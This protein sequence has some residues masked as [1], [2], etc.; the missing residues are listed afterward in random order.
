MS[1][2]SVTRRS[3][4][5]RRT[6]LTWWTVGIALYTAMIM[7]VWPVIEGNEEF[8][9]LF[10]SYPDAIKALMGGPDAFDAFTTPTGFLDT[11]LYSMILP[12][13]F[14]GLAVAIGAALLGG[15]EEEGLLE[16]VLSYPVS[17]TSAVLQKGLAMGAAA[18]GL[19]LVV[20]VLIF[21]MGALVDL[22][23]GLGG[24]AAATL[25]TVLFAL[26]HGQLAMLTGAFTGR[27]GPSLGVGW[28]VALGGYLLSV[29]AGIDQSLSWLNWLSPLHYA[30]NDSP[31]SDG[32]TVWFLVLL[33]ALVLALGA[34]VVAFR[35]HDLR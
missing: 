2:L 21:G 33:A 18:V 16:L 31:I 32:P 34:T 11:Y 5:D 9:E 13:I 1:A 14:V 19:G 8:S 24:L 12:F 15:D 23:V 3:L 4:L 30:T 7:A 17:R 35:R 20:V 6:P 25:G 22:S 28:G 29:M 27:R 10:Q 26:L